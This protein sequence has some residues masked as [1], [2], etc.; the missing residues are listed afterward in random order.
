[1]RS[2]QY[3]EPSSHPCSNIRTGRRKYSELQETISAMQISSAHAAMG[4]CDEHGLMQ[5]GMYVAR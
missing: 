5:F 4:V 3:T 2:E 1:M